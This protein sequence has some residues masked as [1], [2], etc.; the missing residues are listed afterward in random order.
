MIGECLK[1][2]GENGW[3]E[4]KEGRERLYPLHQ[5]VRVSTTICSSTVAVTYTSHFPSVFGAMEGGSVKYVSAIPDE[6]V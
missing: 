6:F 3:I 4:R 5:K 1:V 2:C